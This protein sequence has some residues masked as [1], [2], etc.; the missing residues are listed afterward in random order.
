MHVFVCHP[1]QK[2]LSKNDVC[3][4]EQRTA[5][6]TAGS[7]KSGASKDSCWMPVI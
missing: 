5:G 7:N 4:V 6:G 1:C 3:E 2:G